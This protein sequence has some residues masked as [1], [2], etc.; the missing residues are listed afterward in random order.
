MQRWRRLDTGA[1]LLQMAWPCLSLRLDSQRCPEEKK[2]QHTIQ[3]I[4][5]QEC[6][7]TDATRS[8]SG[9][10]LDMGSGVWKN[11]MIEVKV[12]EAQANGGKRVVEPDIQLEASRLLSRARRR[13]TP[14]RLAACMGARTNRTRPAQATVRGPNSALILDCGSPAR[15]RKLGRMRSSLILIWW[16]TS[17]KDGHF[18]RLSHILCSRSPKT[19]LGLRLMIDLI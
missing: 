4:Q 18:G 13:E 10:L 19:P 7:S 6:A 8:S 1:E 11:R 9:T 15:I 14:A 12:R 17:W 5:L 2:R 16:S 3:L